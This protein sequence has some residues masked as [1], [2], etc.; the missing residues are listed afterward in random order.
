[1]VLEFNK[2]VINSISYKEFGFLTLSSLILAF[3]L[4][5][6]TFSLKYFFISFSLVFSI[7]F[8]FITFSYTYFIKK[9]DLDKELIITTDSLIIVLSVTLFSFIITLLFSFF[10]ESFITFLIP[11]FSSIFSLLIFFFYSLRNNII[12]ITIEKIDELIIGKKNIISTEFLIK[13]LV[14]LF[15]L[16]P[17]SMAIYFFL[18]IVQSLTVIEKKGI[19]IYT[20]TDE[21]ILIIIILYIFKKIFEFIFSKYKDNDKE[22][23]EQFKGTRDLIEYLYNASK[24]V[25]MEKPFK[26]LTTYVYERRDEN[27]FRMIYSLI[28]RYGENKYKLIEKIEEYTDER[29]SS[30]WKT[31]LD[32]IDLEESS[33]KKFISNL[34]S[35]IYLK[36]ITINQI[37]KTIKSTYMYS[38]MIGVL[39]IDVLSSMFYALAKVFQTE[40]V[41]KLQGVDVSK[42][43]FLSNMD[44]TSLPV[45]EIY[46]PVS[47]IGF[48]VGIGTIWYMF[49]RNPQ[50][51]LLR[52]LNSYFVLTIFYIILLGLVKM[53]FLKFTS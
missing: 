16:I 51:L 47:F 34:F 5:F 44:V 2:S 4:S 50:F 6:L 8:T 48:S 40:I 39:I 41:T 33:W 21:I 19:I 37:Y 17:S 52:V 43:S 12:K 20:I 11:F 26:T 13:F 42:L 15:L 22:V 18:K 49:T 28:E 10:S 32:N 31:L 53:M 7:V 24:N 27:F 23:M 46:I 36:S 35:V 38:L 14:N 29:I 30:I 9:R 45:F 25:N 1:M 3:I